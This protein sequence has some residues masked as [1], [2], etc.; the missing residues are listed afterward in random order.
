MK[1][2][3]ITLLTCLALT[4]NAAPKQEPAKDSEVKKACIMIYDAKLKKDVEKCRKI[5]THKKFEGTAV[6]EKKKK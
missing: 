3:L 5:K 6:P 2:L 1:T 4:C